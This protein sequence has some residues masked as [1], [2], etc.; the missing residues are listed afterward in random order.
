MCLDQHEQPQ[1]HSNPSK[2]F[3][4][5]PKEE[6]YSK[7]MATAHNGTIT[8]LCFTPDGQYLLSTGTDGR[9]RCW[10]TK[11]GANTL[12]NYPSTENRFKNGN[13]MAVSANGAIVFHPNDNMINAY[14]V[15]TGAL[16]FQLKGHFDRVNCCL[17][18]PQKEE[19]F[20]GGNDRQILAW[21][22]LPDEQEAEIAQAV[23]DRDTWSD[24]DELF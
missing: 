20:S 15:H 14:H 8:G 19:L 10:N 3:K 4:I 24:D 23:E 17:F 13:Q 22:P 11:T 5:T 9:L 2:R 16:L 6:L 1:Q 7:N 21:T 12:A 18:H